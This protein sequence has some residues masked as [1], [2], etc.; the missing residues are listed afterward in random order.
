MA[1]FRERLE[2]AL[3]NSGLSAADL[4]RI[5]GINEGAISQYR[6][7]AYKASQRTLE[8]LASALSVSIPWLMGLEENESAPSQY[9]EP[10]ITEDIVTFPVIG[11]VAA[12]FEHIAL[13]DW[14]GD[15]ID[16]PE[17]YLHGRSKSDY[18]VLTVK[19]DSMYPLYLEGDKVL[20]LKQSTLNH[21]GEIGLIRYDGE[22]ATLKKV[23]F[24]NGEDWMKLVPINPQYP[25][26]T[27]EGADLELC[28][29]IGIPRLLVRDIK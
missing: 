14:N 12:G 9:P 3:K 2:T 21:S 7:G 18:M 23:E 22:N 13:E 20:V 15:T 16:V 1:T 10:H 25:P 24:V 5:T 6:K 4:S 17:K 29:V 28:E 26:R 11:E 27:I 8:K 19:G